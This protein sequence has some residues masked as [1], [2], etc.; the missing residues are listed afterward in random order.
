MSAPPFMQMYWSDYFGDTRHLSCE[1]H[2]AYLQLLGG[3]WLAGGSLPDDARKLA[4]IT[5]CTASRWA[6]I[7]GD[8]LAFF[9]IADG[10]LTHKRVGIELKKAQEKS[11]KRAVSGSRG[12]TAKA[13]NSH[14]A[15]IANATVLPQHLPEPEPDTERAPTEPSGSAVP[16]GTRP[17]R[18][19]KSRICPAEWSPTMADMA[20]GA[21]EGFTPGEIERELAK[22]RD[23]EFRDPHSEWS[24]TFRKWLRTAA[25]RRPPK[26][27][28]LTAP[29]PDSR[30][31][32]YRERLGD[33]GAA[34]EAAFQQP[35]REH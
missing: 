7:A 14:K 18:K 3:M 16:K 21:V 26:A 6:K 25:E 10:L 33:I 34:M 13:L 19:P 15:N 22:F 28:E 27:H 20:V 1:Q 32:A 30:Q 24:A 29:R 2:G 9:D 17:T 35:R 23:H 4:K 5:G 12:G 8:V 11:I 31:A